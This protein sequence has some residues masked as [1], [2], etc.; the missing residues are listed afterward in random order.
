MT[1]DTQMMTTEEVAEFLNCS[2]KSVRRWLNSGD[3]EGSKLNTRWRI[4]P[5]DVKKFLEDRKNNGNN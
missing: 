1:T 3:L 5:D 4:H 2:E